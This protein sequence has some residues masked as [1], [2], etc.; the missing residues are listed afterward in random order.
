MKAG[1]VFEN[2][3]TGMRVV[4]LQTPEETGGRA[5]QIE[6]R[7]PPHAGR[8]AAPPPRHRIYVERFQV[9]AGRA[10]YV[11][12]DEEHVAE[13][14]QTVVVPEDT[15]H[16]HPWSISDEELVVRQT[17]EATRPD[18]KA[19]TAALVGVR[20]RFALTREGKVDA[21]GQPNLLQSAVIL[22]ALLPNNYLPDIP[23][24]AQR[25]VIG[26]LAGVG[27]LLGYRLSYPRFE[28]QAAPATPAR[29]ATG[30]AA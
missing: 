24:L 10:A 15:T 12:G 11:V 21:H 22:N 25:L 3:L 19:M 2:P 13:V 16:I 8:D 7:H 14:G 18:G 1:D 27:Q 23:L 20:T 6:Y 26:V 4:V 9:L 17:T 5:M 28:A 30:E 29:A